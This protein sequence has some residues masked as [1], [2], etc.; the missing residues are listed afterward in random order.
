MTVS[1]AISG[2]PRPYG[3]EMAANFGAEAA[4]HMVTRTMQQAEL[5]VTELLVHQPPGLVSDPLERQNAYLICCQVQDKPPFEY[6]EDGRAFASPTIR[7]GETTIHDLRRDPTAKI[8]APIH[9]MMWLVP[10]AAMDALADDAN[11]PCVDELNFDPLVGLGDETI[12]HLSAALMPALRSPEQV[13]R[14][15]V[16]HATLAMA[17]HVAHAYGGLQIGGRL[18]K[19]GLAP[20]Q[21]RRAKEMLVADLAGDTPLAKLAAGCGLSP[22]HF[23]RAFRK[24]TGLA[25]HAWLLQARVDR[26]LALLRNHDPSLSE[27]A[28]T[29]GFVDQSHFT[30]VFVR[31][32]GIT[33]GAWRRMMVS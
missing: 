5:A 28:L 13:S 17:A 30:R 14:L 25:P 12:R 18:V 27:I 21:L 22:D 3:H 7:A 15:F 20:W 23:A 29:C 33:P 16:D 6:W 31:R 19:G 10:R 1:Q 26:A 24:S 11:I 9:T 2:R 32:V 8:D 4:P